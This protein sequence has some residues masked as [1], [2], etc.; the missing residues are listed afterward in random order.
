MT[1]KTVSE[2]QLPVVILTLFMG[3]SYR[4]RPTVPLVLIVT[5]YLSKSPGTHEAFDPCQALP[6]PTPGFSPQQRQ[7]RPGG[8]G[9]QPP[10]Q[11]NKA[12][13]AERRP[14]GVAAV[15]TLRRDLSGWGQSRP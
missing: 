13:E 7:H 6:G 14:L 8:G 3:C 12:A 2:E 5:R 11:S 15:P 1:F 4:H 10:C 9:S